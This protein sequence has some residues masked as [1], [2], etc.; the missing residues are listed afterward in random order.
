MVDRDESVIWKISLIAWAIFLITFVFFLPNILLW[1]FWWQ[2]LDFSSLNTKIVNGWIERT[3]SSEKVTD[4]CSNILFMGIKENHRLFKENTKESLST[5]GLWLSSFMDRR[6]TSLSSNCSFFYDKWIFQIPQNEMVL[7]E[8]DTLPKELELK[9][10]IKKNELKT[11]FEDYTEYGFYKN[12]FLY[13]FYFVS[14]IIGLRI[15]FLIIDIF[16][17]IKIHPLKY[18]KIHLF[19]LNSKIFRELFFD[20]KSEIDVELYK[21]FL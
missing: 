2:K 9:N 1:T 11:S 18:D 8:M 4:M 12:F 15:L 10:I 21:F 19:I 13:L 16:T 6:F 14:F 7:Y 3:M 20:T 17:I 5:L